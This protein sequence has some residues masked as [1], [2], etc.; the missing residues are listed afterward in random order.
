MR[1]KSGRADN[2]P[3]IPYV[4]VGIVRVV[5]GDVTGTLQSPCDM[6]QFDAFRNSQ[7]HDINPG[8]DADPQ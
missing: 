4:V 1:P 8:L 6:V 2:L 3:D 7:N 5:P